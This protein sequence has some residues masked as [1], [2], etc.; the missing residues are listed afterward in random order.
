MRIPFLPST[1]LAVVC[2]QL[3]MDNDACQQQCDAYTD[4]YDLHREFWNATAD[5]SPDAKQIWQRFYEFTRVVCGKCALAKIDCGCSRGLENP[6]FQ[7]LYEY[8]EFVIWASNFSRQSHDDD[9]AVSCVLLDISQPTGIGNQLLST[10]NALLLSL[11][12]RRALTVKFP[13]SQRYDLDPVFDFDA[14]K[15]A[16]CRSCDYVET[17]DLSSVNGLSSVM[18]ED[19]QL[20]IEGEECILLKNSVQAPTN[21]CP[22]TQA[23]N[24]QLQTT[25]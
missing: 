18:C 7:L 24:P 16:A 9:M 22:R 11:I 4:P 6:P 8:T 19:F 25:R 23:R 5:A 2:L 21:L 14:D 20:I 17:L 10:I 3:R 13:A 1:L 15:S 12:T